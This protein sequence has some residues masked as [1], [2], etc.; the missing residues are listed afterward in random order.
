[1]KLGKY[2]MIVKKNMEE[3]Y[4]TRF[5]ELTMEGTI[6]DR[7]LEREQ[8][9]LRQKEIIEQQLKEEKPAPKTEA[10]TEQ[11]KY[12]QMIANLVEEELKPMLEEKI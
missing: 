2:G 11:A 8:E 9:I 12:N 6:M 4:P 10:F 7:L 1:M 3:M 5:D